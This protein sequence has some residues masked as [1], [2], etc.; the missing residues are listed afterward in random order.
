MKYLIL[1]T[2]IKL[3]NNYNNDS[4][5]INKKIKELILL[6]IQIQEKMTSNFNYKKQL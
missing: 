1:I 6:Y 3:I 5:Q 2:L 4:R